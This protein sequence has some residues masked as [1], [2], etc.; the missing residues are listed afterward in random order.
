MCAGLPLR[1]KV[2]RDLPSRLDLLNGSMDSVANAEVGSA[3][4]DV[5]CHSVVNL[6]ISG[7]RMRREQSCCR[8]DLAGLAISALRNLLGDPGLLDGMEAFRTQAFDRDD[9][10]ACGALHWSLAGAYSFSIQMNG[11]SAA[12]AYAAA[13]LG[14]GHLQQ[15]AQNPQQGH[16][17]FRVYGKRTSVDVKSES[18]HQTTSLAA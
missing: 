6:G 18:G 7:S 10:V 9:P 17:C 2:F 16:I 4:A 12:H 3:P 14:S 15:V 8:H 11:T 13:V 5:A 1:T